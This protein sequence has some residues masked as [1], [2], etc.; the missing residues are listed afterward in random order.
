[1][2]VDFKWNLFL[3]G[4]EQ[5]NTW[6]KSVNYLQLE[7]L[8]FGDLVPGEETTSQSVHTMTSKLLYHTSY[9]NVAKGDMLLLMAY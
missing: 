4:V 5:A 2:Q 9:S 7:H 6:L 1:M 8:N 3:N